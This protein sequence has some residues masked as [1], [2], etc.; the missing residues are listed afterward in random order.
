MKAFVIYLPDRE[1]SVTHSAYMLETLRGYGIDAELSVGTPGDQAV[2]M[3]EK[4]NKVLYPFSI[5]NQLLTEHEIQEYIRPELWD[6]FK[7][8]F[9]YKIYRRQY[10]GQEDIPKLSRPGVIGC[11]YSHYAL[12][13]K[14]IDL[15]EPIMIFEDDVKFYRKYFNFDCK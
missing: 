15:G 3:A 11:F 1:H 5:K 10:V 13:R 7:K 9:H 14:C 4:A 6:E 2:E 8:E 12:W